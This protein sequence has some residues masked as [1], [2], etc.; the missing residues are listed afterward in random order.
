MSN[1]Q[2]FQNS[3]PSP[4][5]PLSVIAGQ[6]TV[7]TTEMLERI[8]LQSTTD[9][10]NIFDTILIHAEEVFGKSSKALDWLQTE[11]KS[12]AGKRPYDL[13]NSP[14]GNKQVLDLLHAIEYGSFS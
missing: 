5:L 1:K 9:K 11:N 3:T 12:L 7:V 4:T 6:G 14:E 10:N 2:P 8:M 13:I